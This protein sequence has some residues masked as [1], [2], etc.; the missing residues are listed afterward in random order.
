LHGST[1]IFAGVGTYTPSRGFGNPN[2][3]ACEIAR[4]H[5]GSLDVTSGQE[6]TRFTFSMPLA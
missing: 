4:P 2:N 5:S 1:F 6:E 3:P